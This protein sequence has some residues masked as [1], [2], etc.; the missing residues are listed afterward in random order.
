MTIQATLCRFRR[1]RTLLVLTV[2]LAC[3][4]ALGAARPYS[5]A[6]G[7]AAGARTLHLAV[8]KP[9]TVITGSTVTLRCR[10][11]DQAGKAIKGVKVTFRWYLPDGTA[12]QRRVT[13][14]QGLATAGR[15]VDCGSADSFDA[16]AIVTAVWRGQTRK[17]TRAFTVIGG[18]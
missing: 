2:A 7:I 10:A 12:T 4:L 8:N 1:R 11:K 13:S 9:G 18:T 14:S 16:R 3:A 17:V 5:A 15:L 6:A